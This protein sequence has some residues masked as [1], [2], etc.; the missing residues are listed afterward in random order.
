MGVLI[1]MLAALG[2]FSLVLYELIDPVLNKKQETGAEGMI[3][4]RGKVVIPLTPEGLIKVQG[5]LWKAYSTNVKSLITSVSVM[6]RRSS[7]A[8]GFCFKG[9]E[10]GMKGSTRVLRE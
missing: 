7:Q 5:E 6:Q 1:A 4:R 9:R 8:S 2:V 3:G 10:D